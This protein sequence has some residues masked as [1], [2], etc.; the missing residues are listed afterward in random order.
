VAKTTVG[1]DEGTG[2]IVTRCKRRALGVGKGREIPLK[3]VLAGKMAEP[4]D[5]HKVSVFPL[6][7]EI[8]QSGNMRGRSD[9]S[10]LRARVGDSEYPDSERHLGLGRGARFKGRSLMYDVSSHFF[11]K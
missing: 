10:S 9:W 6:T 3:Y 8:N 5:W 4:T 2:R 1:V 11:P 7:F